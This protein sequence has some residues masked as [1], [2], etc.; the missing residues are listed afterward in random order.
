MK[1]LLMVNI[2]LVI[3]N[4]LIVSCGEVKASGGYRIEI[5]FGYTCITNDVSIWCDNQ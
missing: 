5:M 1:K 4:M 2:F 3:L